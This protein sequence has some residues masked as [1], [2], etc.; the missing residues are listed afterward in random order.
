MTEEIKNKIETFKKQCERMENHLND[1][2]TKLFLDD[3]K[4][5]EDILEV[6]NEMKELEK[7]AKELKDE[8]AL[9]RSDIAKKSITEINQIIQNFKQ[10]LKQIKQKQINQY[11]N[12]VINLNDR[13]KKIKEVNKDDLSNELKDEID[14]LV[15]LDNVN[16]SVNDW[17]HNAYLGELDYRKLLETT[18]IVTGLE[19]KINIPKTYDN[20]YEEG[21]QLLE[22]KINKTNKE[23]KD[24]F[25]LEE[26]NKLLEQNGIYFDELMDLEI[27]IRKNEEDIEVSKYKEYQNILKDLKKKLNEIEERL[28][29]IKKNS[30]QENVL[31]NELKDMLKVLNDKT[32]NLRSKVNTFFG[33]CDVDTKKLFE[34]YLKELI[35]KLA[36]IEGMVPDK[37]EKKMDE[38]QHESINADVERIKNSFDKLTNRLNDPFVMEDHDIFAFLNSNIDVLNDEVN[39]LDVT[40]EKL[41][42]PITD[43][44]TRKKI[45]MTIKYLETKYNK[46]LNILKECKIDNLEKYNEIKEKLDKVGNDL[47]KVGKKYRSK[48]PILVRTVKSAK[49]FFKK[50]KKEALIIAGLS[51]MVLILGHS[52]II[53]AIMHGNIMIGASRTSKGIWYLSNGVR[54]NSSLASASLLKGLAYSGLGNA[55]LLSPVI[56]GVVISIK[57][58]IGKIKNVELKQNL[59]ENNDINEEDDK[60]D[61]SKDNKKNLED[62]VSKDML[63]LFKKYKKSGLELKV[64]A[65]NNKLTE[66]EIQ[67]LMTLDE[68]I[69]EKEEQDV[70]SKGGRK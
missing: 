10:R 62:L 1:I 46:Y 34:Q 14:K 67:I 3:I 23:I 33:K 12:R 30:Y 43:K 6:T 13:I 40:I 21:L 15:E 19:T 49:H 45:D 26:S 58:L 66:K 38:N 70:R 64:F 22:D 24:D 2:D 54:L 9:F 18:K 60:K 7:L 29:E 31:F 41:P 42:K 47:E 36:K 8:I 16:V 59:K 20:E 32:F 25:S 5:T 63:K 37:K 27:K 51:A 65:I 11:K 44:E 35:N 56:A 55:V 53:P 52:V 17:R 4:I 61:K 48:S 68:M 39:D 69:K 57:N 28:L 50:H